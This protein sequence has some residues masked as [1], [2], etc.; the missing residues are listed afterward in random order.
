[1]GNNSYTI[2]GTLSG[3]SRDTLSLT[4]KGIDLSPL[5]S[6][7][8]GKES[9]IQFDLKGII[10]GNILISSTLKNPLIQSNIGVNGFSIL[11]GDYGDLS[12]LSLW[13]SDRRVADIN[14]SNNLNGKKNIDISGNYDPRTKKFNLTG[15]A[16]NLPVDALNPLLSF[17]ASGIKGNVSGKVKL[18]GAPGELVLTGALMAEK[19]SMK[20][21]YLQTKYSIND[22]IR[23][24]KSGIIFKNIRVT[25]ERGNDALLSGSVFHK[26]F[27]GFSVDLTVNMDKN[28]CLVLNTQQKDNEL[29]YGTVFASGVTTIKSGPNSL[30]FDISAKT[31]KGT[32]FFI[33]ID[34]G[35]SVS[36]SS[37][38]TFINHDTT[39]IAGENRLL[40]AA[41]KPSD[42][43]L[44]LNVD[45]D[46]TPDA[47]VQLLIDPKAGDV[48]K[49]R[50][51][52]SLNISLNKNGEFKIFGDYI[53]EE[54]D[55]LFTLKNIL[56]K[57]FDVE[58]GGKITF[59]GDVEN[60][61]I[62]LTA[63]YG[64]LKTS[65]YPIL[66]PILQD[67]KYN[68]RIPVEPQLNLSGKLFNPVVVFNI[69]LP[70]A[71]EETRTYLRNAINTEEEL[72]K[73][74]LYLLVMNSFYAD[75]T[76]RASGASSSGTSAMA[77]TT[78]EM[79][80][81]QVSNWLSQISNDFDVGLLY[82]PGTKDINSQELQVAL[83]TQITE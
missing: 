78:T 68:A 79:L 12:V 13:N 21:D 30:S 64:N 50:G 15:I 62:D 36:E 11:G 33:P 52:G 8:E 24:N 27:K 57:R 41:I 56:N 59:N 14:V 6:M 83:S 19:T 29:F 38:V 66:Y 18:T 58:N 5:S 76:Y 72:S 69:Y 2:D 75:P 51:S 55:Y 10:N 46:V 26:N 28:A 81:N 80:S 35:L 53:I 73:Q 54:G 7:T 4:F 32:R 82:R 49:G 16:S 37:F 1:M 3:N 25:D 45:L 40:T 71:D 63:K 70:N 22:S 9:D 61:E 44:E 39:L 31:G 23:F 65:L 17:F 42:S 43:S 74:F 48:I 34:Y 47:E 60:A 77:V 20:I 67:E